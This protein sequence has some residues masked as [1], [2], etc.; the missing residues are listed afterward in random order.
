MGLMT[1]VQ[2]RGSVYYF[3]R[4]VPLDLQ[5]VI[6]RAVIKESLKERDPTR[7][8]QVHAQRAA[9][10]EEHFA[11]LRRRI[12]A[13]KGPVRQDLTPE[14]VKWLADE[15]RRMFLYADEQTRLCG[16]GG[17]ENGLPQDQFDRHGYALEQIEQFARRDLARGHVLSAARLWH[18]DEFLG[19]RG[20]KL[21]PRCPAYRQLATE[22]LI[23]QVE[24]TA[25]ARKRQAGEVVR[26]PAAADIPSAPAAEPVRK[27]TPE[28]LVAGW[29]R[30]REPA[31]KTVYTFRK[32]VEAFA[33]FLGGDLTRADADAAANW[34]LSLLEHK[35]AKTVANQ[36]A[37]CKAVF[38][39]AR[40]NRVIASNPFAEVKA[41]KLKKGSKKRGYTG[42]EV[43]L[44][45][46][47][48]RAFTGWRRWVPWLLYLTGARIAE[49]C[50]LSAADIRCWRG[51]WY[52]EITTLSDDD[53][54]EED[55]GVKSVKTPSS[56]RR[57]PIHQALI[58]EGFLAFVRTKKG[59][60]FHEITPDRFGSR[61]GNASKINGRWVREDLGIKDPRIQPAHAF[62]HLFK[63]LC[64]DAG[65]TQETHDALTGHSVAG[66]GAEYGEKVGLEMRAE[67][68]KLI[69]LPEG[70]CP[71]EAA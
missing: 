50:Q 37:G 63:S 13:E 9:W 52:L 71:L 12:A 11:L 60:L 34:K 47:A 61:G 6:G 70:L 26:T 58:D 23:A 66:E 24:A 45:L 30:E 49:I 56:R 38:A 42:D 46:E 31:E 69:P 2:R 17:Q 5:A 10:W 43:R 33:A 67:A 64:R 36:I 68:I 57:V 14:E 18:Y 62:R 29:R 65:I 1:N 51:I 27:I 8:R 19:E 16:L 15:Y 21:D 22:F 44:I 25:E 41:P 32:H 7:A 4:R 40:E 55:E 3:R 20:I 28:M 54:D 59:L 35:T 48:A 53:D 39:W